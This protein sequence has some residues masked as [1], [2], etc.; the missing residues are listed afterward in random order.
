MNF[1]NEVSIKRKITEKKIFNFCFE[2]KSK[3]FFKIMENGQ[4]LILLFLKISLK[5]TFNKP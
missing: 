2:E 5:N 1:R 3:Y 4:F